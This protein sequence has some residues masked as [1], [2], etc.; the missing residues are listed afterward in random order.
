MA[1]LIGLGLENFRVF[2]EYTEFDFAPITLL[3]GAN[4]SGKSSLIKALLL[5]ADNAKENDLTKTFFNNND[6]NL[7]SFEQVI[8]HHNKHRDNSTIGMN[9]LYHLSNKEIIG[10]YPSYEEINKKLT[11][12]D[13][14]ELRIRIE[15]NDLVK[16]FNYILDNEKKEFEDYKLKLLAKIQSLNIKAEGLEFFIEQINDN[17]LIN[18]LKSL[19]YIPANRGTQKRFYA[20]NKNSFFDDLLITYKNLPFTDQE[21]LIK[22]IKT[23]FVRKFNLADDIR[24]TSIKTYGNAIEVEKNNTWIDLADI[25]FGSTQIL[26]LIFRIG[27]IERKNYVQYV[28]IEE[29]E[30][31]LHPNLQSKLADFFVKMSTELNVHFIIETHSEY[32]IRKLQYLTAN[33]EIKPEYTVIYYFYE[34]DRDAKDK[35]PQDE[36]SDPEG[37]KQVELIRIQEDGRLDQEFGEGFF[38]EAAQLIGQLWQQQ[39]QN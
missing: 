36:K 34:P 38:D 21:K 13:K 2:K 24:L 33:K 31:N 7:G 22:F 1:Q 15:K 19:I 5:L 30:T 9:L 35:E 37:K 25:G 27:L 12:L 18:S 39:M 23:W 3:T 6:H 26:P 20:F 4:N 10:K 14:L 28:I 8:C 29:P 11:L 17:A 32:L 16:H